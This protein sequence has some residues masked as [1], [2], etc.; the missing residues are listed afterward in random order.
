MKFITILN[1]LIFLNIL[2]KAQLFEQSV[3]SPRFLQEKDKEVLF[4]KTLFS[5]MSLISP[6]LNETF[7]LNNDYIK[8][9]IIKEKQGTFLPDF[10]RDDIAPKIIKEQINNQFKD[11]INTSALNIKNKTINFDRDTV[12]NV[13]NFTLG[14]EQLKNLIVFNVK[15]MKKCGKNLEFCMI[16]DNGLD[17]IVLQEDNNMKFLQLENEPE[18]ENDLD[19]TDNELNLD[20]LTEINDN[21][22]ENL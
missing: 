2:I 11:E 12:I 1:I 19:I 9:E 18:I 7:P 5:N 10:I 15:L 6:I 13:G 3:L 16:K 20:N 8:K 21:I 17:D 4:Q 14:I 22:Y